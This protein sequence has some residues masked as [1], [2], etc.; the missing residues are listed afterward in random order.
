M[1]KQDLLLHDPHSVNTHPIFGRDPESY[2]VGGKQEARTN[3]IT[4]TSGNSEPV[5]LLS[6]RHKHSLEER[7][8]RRTL[9]DDS[10]GAGRLSIPNMGLVT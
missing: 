5:R 10:T 2:Y 3:H 4:F 1:S 8:L 6:R 7:H 9:I